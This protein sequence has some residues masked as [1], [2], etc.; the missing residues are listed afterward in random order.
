MKGW[1]YI[2]DDNGLRFSYEHLQRALKEAKAMSVDQLAEYVDAV[3]F[4]SV[5]NIGPALVPDKL[6]KEINMTAIG[7][8]AFL[9]LHSPYPQVKQKCAILLEQFKK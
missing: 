7:N 8:V 5:A 2:F 9:F 1:I 4:A 3:T 6:P